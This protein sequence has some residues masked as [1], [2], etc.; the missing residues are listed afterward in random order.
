[1]N[2]TAAGG[3]V[4]NTS[5]CQKSSTC[6]EYQHDLMMDPQGPEVM[7]VSNE[8]YP[9]V[10]PAPHAPQV[11]SMPRTPYPPVKHFPTQSPM[12]TRY[13]ET[14]HP[15]RDVNHT[16]MDGSS[17]IVLGSKRRRLEFLHPAIPSQRPEHD[18]CHE[19]SQ[20]HISLANYRLPQS[21][22]RVSARR[23]S[24]PA[25]RE[26]IPEVSPRTVAPSPG[27]TVA[28]GP[29]Y[30]QHRMLMKRGPVGKDLSLTLPPLNASATKHESGQSGSSGFA[31][32]IPATGS[33]PQ[34]AFRQSFPGR[35]V[36]LVMLLHKQAV[37]K[38]VL[39]IPPPVAK[40]PQ[41]AVVI[42]IDGD[43][44]EAIDYLSHCL[45]ET[46]RLTAGSNASFM[47]TPRLPLTK[48]TSEERRFECLDSVKEWCKKSMEIFDFM[49]GNP[50][51][52]ES[53]SDS[54]DA[55]QAMTMGPRTGDQPS[56][57]L[58]IRSWLMSTIDRYTVWIPATNDHRVTEHWEW[59]AYMWQGVVAPDLIIYVRA[60][61]IEEI[62]ER[63]ATEVADGG[64]LMLIRHSKDDTVRDP[65]GQRTHGFQSGALRRIGFEVGEW[66]EG[67]RVECET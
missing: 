52:S 8:S 57:V 36:P 53:M 43:D 14:Y 30:S 32:A 26:F 16:D 41:R 34:T 33:A 39:R 5:S 63:G 59:T 48:D 12:E 15:K 50:I 23:E 49:M 7:H 62:S 21:E 20:G 38:K 27:L 45:A 61:S 22:N 44:P 58:F 56:P 64:N 1:M 10:F 2:D 3:V 13:P 17:E 67:R 11:M 19:H 37:L 24:L 29:G 35:L 28:P 55:D 47:D 9:R 54:T 18:N 66:L 31:T 46:L 42:A 60:A 4:R 6:S 65:D 40:R 51:K 25:A